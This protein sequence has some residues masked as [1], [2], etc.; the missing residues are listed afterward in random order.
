MAETKAIFGLAPG[1]VCLAPVPAAAS[2]AAGFVEH[3]QQLAA[4]RARPIPPRIAGWCW[5]YFVQVA[6]SPSVQGGITT[7]ADVGSSR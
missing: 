3:S 2:A 1:Q 4:R 6:N 7:C 5:Q